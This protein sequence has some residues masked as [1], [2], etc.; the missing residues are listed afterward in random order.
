MKFVK[1]AVVG[2]A[3]S[4]GLL[5]ATI[6][7]AS[8]MTVTKS[9]FVVNAEGHFVAGMKGTTKMTETAKG[10]FTVS[11]KAN[12]V[13]YIVEAHNLGMVTSATISLGMK[14]DNGMKEVTLS[15]HDISAGMMHFPCVAISHTLAS[16]ILEHPANHYFQIA[17]PAFPHGV[18]RGQL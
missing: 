17:N 4:S 3:L 15:A 16:A 7:G 18:V 9:T 2:V 1:F 14:G 11:S 13:C 6:A 12:D 5:S 8:S 10:T